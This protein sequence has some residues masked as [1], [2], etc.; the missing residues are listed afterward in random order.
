MQSSIYQ[1][2][3]Q[4]TKQTLVL[5]V[6]PCIRIFKIFVFNTVG[7]ISW[8]IIFLPSKICR[9]EN[10]YPNWLDLWVRVNF[11]L[12]CRTETS[13]LDWNSQS[14][15]VTNALWVYRDLE[16][17]TSLKICVFIPLCPSCIHQRGHSSTSVRSGNKPPQGL[18]VRAWARTTV[19]VANLP[20]GSDVANIHPDAFD[21]LSPS[22]VVLIYSRA[23]WKWCLEWVQRKV[24]THTSGSIPRHLHHSIITLLWG[25]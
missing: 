3:S 19:S 24:W 4:T 1:F 15:H 25:M 23:D 8:V 20:Q 14:V 5:V 17:Q 12:C 21:F 7:W 16:L 11:Q 18:I 9:R 2:S 13:P 10:K 22:A 6:R